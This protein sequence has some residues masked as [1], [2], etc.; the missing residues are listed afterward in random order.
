MNETLRVI[1]S[2]CSNHHGFTEEPVTD[3]ELEL[4]LSACMRAPNASNRQRYSIVVLDDPT[5]IKELAR[6]TGYKALMFC[7]DSNRIMDTA[8]H[9]GLEYKLGDISPFVTGLTDTVL[10]AQTAAIAARSMGLDVLFS[11]RMFRNVS[12]IYELLELPQAYCFP[13]ALLLLGHAKVAP[14][15]KMGR[16]RGPG[17][18]HYGTYRRASAQ[19]LE[20]LVHQYDAPHMGLNPTWKDKGYAHYLEW[21]FNKWTAKSERGEQHSEM[22]QVLK[23]SGYLE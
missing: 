9:M 12:T 20:S 17:I 10:A 7:V 23:R 18:V 8:A 19:E 13:V 1:H 4:I 15:Y 2:L 16:I 3:A 14:K 6:T 11:T 21:F 22:F 5:V